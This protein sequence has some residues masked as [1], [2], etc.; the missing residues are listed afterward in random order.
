MLEFEKDVTYYENLEG[1]H[2]GAADNK[3]RAFMSALQYQFLWRHLTVERA[4]TG[5]E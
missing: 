2:A 1:G 5:H 4:T 3:Q